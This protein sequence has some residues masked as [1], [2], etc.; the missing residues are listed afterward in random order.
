MIF[1]GEGIEPERGLSWRRAGS[2]AAR[3]ATLLLKGEDKDLVEYAKVEHIKAAKG[4]KTAEKPMILAALPKITS[5]AV[6][7]I[8]V[9]LLDSISPHGDPATA[10]SLQRIVADAERNGDP[11][12]MRLNAAFPTVIYRLRA[13]AE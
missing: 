5:P 6:R 7:F 1:S 11:G 8:A 2:L 13:R 3:R 9:T 12:A 4:D 10:L